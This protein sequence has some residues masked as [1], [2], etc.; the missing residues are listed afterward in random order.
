MTNIQILALAL[1]VLPAKTLATTMRP[2]AFSES[3]PVQ[4]TS[5]A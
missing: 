2:A 3:V 4:Y 5:C 1:K